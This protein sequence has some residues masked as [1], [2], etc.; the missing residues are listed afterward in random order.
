MKRYI[1]TAIDTLSALDCRLDHED[2]ELRHDRWIFTHLNAPDETFKI[3]LH[4]SEASVRT[5]IQRARVAAGLATSGAT[6]RQPKV[7]QRVKA[8]RA[9]ERGRIETVRRLA[10][11]ERAREQAQVAAVAVMHREKELDS[12]LRGRP[13]ENSGGLTVEAGAMLTVE[14]VADQTGLTDKA[15]QRAIDSGV[16]E[17]YQCGKQV[18]VKGSDVR[19]WLGESA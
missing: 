1:K 2:R 16:L 4:S 6:E 17:A 10:A 14:Q 5:V 8:E 15:V 3:S 12:L 18:K 13:S 11:A 19:T 7:N 9:A